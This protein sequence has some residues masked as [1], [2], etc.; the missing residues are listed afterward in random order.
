M[1]L[2]TLRAQL[3]AAPV[4]P[5]FYALTEA[6]RAKAFGICASLVT[7]GQNAM[8][9]PSE[10]PPF[11]CVS[12][13]L[14][15]DDEQDRGIAWEACVRLLKWGVQ[16]PWF[17]TTVE[18]LA[19]K[20][21]IPGYAVEVVLRLDRRDQVKPNMRTSVIHYASALRDRIDTEMRA[22]LK[23]NP[24][25]I[26]SS[27]RLVVPSYSWE[28]VRD[29]IATAL[30][31]F[32]STIRLKRG[33]LSHKAYVRMPDVSTKWDAAT[34]VIETVFTRGSLKELKKKHTK[35]EVTS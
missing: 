30:I 19:L 26:T 10:G 13:L 21:N 16:D 6:D 8:H 34:V 33:Y 3:Q 15:F 17:N 1:S 28:H 23:V 25:A 29:G 5:E 35:S 2:N 7:K 11:T 18:L 27:L 24:G 14:P 12:M 32:D 31:I 9:A 20:E 22:Y 4:I